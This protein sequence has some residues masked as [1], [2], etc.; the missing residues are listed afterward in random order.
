MSDYTLKVENITYFHE[1]REFE[2]K[3]AKFANICY[4]KI[5]QKYEIR[6]IYHKNSLIWKMNNSCMHQCIKETFLQG[7]DY[8][9]GLWRQI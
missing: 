7:V 9:L 4:H 5:F 3:I 2:K 8:R 1:F 6:E